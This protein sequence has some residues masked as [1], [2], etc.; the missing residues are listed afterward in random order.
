MNKFNFSLK[1]STYPSNVYLYES[2]Y[3]PWIQYF[4]QGKHCL[5]ICCIHLPLQAITV[6][7]RGLFGLWG[8][9]DMNPMPL[10]IMILGCLSRPGWDSGVGTKGW[11][12]T[13]YHLTQQYFWPQV[14]LVPMPVTS[15]PSPNDL[16]APIFF[17]PTLTNEYQQS[18]YWPC[19]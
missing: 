11:S 9:Q 2:I 15:Y 17:L 18:S 6:Y 13:C 16:L 10:V 8:W 7:F 12:I 3:A 1:N 14:P 5:E 19:T 4:V